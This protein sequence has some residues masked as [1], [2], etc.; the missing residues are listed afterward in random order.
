MA[1]KPPK[2]K[3]H[4]FYAYYD[5]PTGTILAV[6]NEKNTNYSHGIEIDHSLHKK[7]SSNVERFEDYKIGHVKTE[8]NKTVAMVLAN[9]DRLFD[10]KNT[11][12]EI[13]ESKPKIDTE[14]I[15]TWHKPW[16]KW[17]F[18]ISKS[19]AARLQSNVNTQQQV[20]FFVTLAD[21]LDFLI[22]DMVINVN[23][24]ISKQYLEAEFVSHLEFKIDKISISTQMIFESHGIEIIND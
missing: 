21:D 9:K 10:F 14:I 17:I 12:I 11:M 22:R 4:K 1:R 6:S 3:E 13:I 5:K 16:E 15:V 20:L 18:K 23:D 2:Y 19:C 7:L 8:D 24:L